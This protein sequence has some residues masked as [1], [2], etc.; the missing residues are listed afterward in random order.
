MRPRRMTYR[1]PIVTKGTQSISQ[2]IPVNLGVFVEKG[3]VIGTFATGGVLGGE[4]RGVPA[5]K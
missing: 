5:G 1:C 2:Y 3:G 4:A